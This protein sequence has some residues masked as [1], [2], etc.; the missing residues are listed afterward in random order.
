MEIGGVVSRNYDLLLRIL[1][2]A[3]IFPLCEIRACSRCGSGDLR[4]GVVVVPTCC[5][6]NGSIWRSY[7][8]D[9]SWWK[10]GSAENGSSEEE[11]VGPSLP[12]LWLLKARHITF[13]KKSQDAQKGRS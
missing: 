12:S 2:S 4:L 7:L 5:R 6:R 8:E 9:S 11:D 10:D 3:R 1:G 13:L